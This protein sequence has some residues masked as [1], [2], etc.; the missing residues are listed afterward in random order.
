MYDTTN[1]PAIIGAQLEVRISTQTLAAIFL[2]GALI[3]LT[4]FVAKKFFT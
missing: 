2:T 4:Y 1:P 3:V